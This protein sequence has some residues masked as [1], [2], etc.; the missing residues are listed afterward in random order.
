[1][2]SLRLGDRVPNFS[3]SSTHGDLILHH[4][5]E[6]NW[7]IVFACPDVFDPV[8]FSEILEFVR[9]EDELTQRRV[10]VCGMICKGLDS[11]KLLVEDVKALVG[12][13]PSFPLFEDPEGD[14][15][16][17]FGLLKENKERNWDFKKV[18]GIF[19]INP[20]KKIAAILQYPRRVG[21]NF[22]EILRLIDSLQLE[23]F[24]Q[25]QTPASWVR[26]QNVLIQ[27]KKR[28]QRRRSNAS[29]IN[30][31]TIRSVELPSKM[32]YFITASD[33]VQDHNDLW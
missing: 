3:Y 14:L 10:K 11:L 9:L 25:V 1:M 31:D 12:K 22:H 13:E 2:A 26:G 4:Y 18:R 21:A 29:R 5:L 32:N 27:A 15:A 16:A 23:A 8:Y 24:K 6:E 20:S 17:Q 28:Y 33:P 19:I 7:G 30:E